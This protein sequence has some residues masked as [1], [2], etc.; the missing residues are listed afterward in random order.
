MAG[1]EKYLPELEQYI[2][3]RLGQH[4][5]VLCERTYAP[6]TLRAPTAV[7]V[8]L[9]EHRKEAFREMLFQ[10]IDDSGLADAEIYRKAG[11]DRRHFSKIRSNSDYR[12]SKQTV[13]ALILALELDLDAAEE[14]LET[15]G[16]SLSYSDTAD[17][18][19]RF[20]LEKGIYNLFDVNL[21]LSHYG[22]RALG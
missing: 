14:L 4:P 19:I 16:Y 9:L 5:L 17:L 6:Q 21:L 11:L 12:P 13:V 7:D 18:I 20:C 2:A 3:K 1:A 22:Q 10:H 8:F 15:G